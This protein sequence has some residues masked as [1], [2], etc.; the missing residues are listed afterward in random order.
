M[1]YIT[2]TYTV[3][4]LY[5]TRYCSGQEIHEFRGGKSG[6]YCI[7]ILTLFLTCLLLIHVHLTVAIMVTPYSKNIIPHC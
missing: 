3:S 1:E 2:I 5:L 7:V 6:R 4:P